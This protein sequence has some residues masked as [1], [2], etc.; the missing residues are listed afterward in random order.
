MS[1]FPAA[2]RLLPGTAV[3]SQGTPE[4]QPGWLGHTCVSAAVAGRGARQGRYV[5][6]SR[7]ALS[8]SNPGHG[9]VSSHAWRCRKPF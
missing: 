7:A 1:H 9:A 2:A 4:S 3:T 6:L 5:A 8:L